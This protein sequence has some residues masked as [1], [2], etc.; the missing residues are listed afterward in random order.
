MSSLIRPI[1]KTKSKA[2]K[3]F[4]IASIIFAGPV[5]FLL[6]DYYL[7]WLQ[8]NS[9]TIVWYLAFLYDMLGA[10]GGVALSFSI[11]I[12]LYFIGMKMH[13]RRQLYAIHQ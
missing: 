11:A 6:Y 9:T 5:S 10:W 2:A 13:A 8:S 1:V 7:T 12:V 4:F 3:I